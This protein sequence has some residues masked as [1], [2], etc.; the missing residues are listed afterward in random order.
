MYLFIFTLLL[1]LFQIVNSKNILERYEDRIVRLENREADYKQ[2]IENLEN[3]NFDLALF[4]IKGNEDALSYFEASGY[5]TSQL[6]P[7]VEEE[8]YK[9]NEYEGD[10]HPIV[11]YVSMTEGK[12]LIDQM[13]IINHKWIIANFTDGKHWGE[14]LVSY[15][16]DEEKNLKFKLIE[17][18][19]YPTIQ[20]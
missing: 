14:I 12:M 3:E 9:L 11:P 2:T 17:Y 18:F 16:I 6:L 10:D 4:N 7:L 13:R 5:K 15:E 1:V 8:F 19:M 20:Y